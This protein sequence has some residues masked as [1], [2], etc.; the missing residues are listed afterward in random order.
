MDFIEIQTFMTLLS[1]AILVIGTIIGL[2]TFK[3]LNNVHKGIAVYLAAMLFVDLNSRLFHTLFNNN[4]IILLLYSF[5]ELSLLAYFYNKYLFKQKYKVLIA[6]N[7]ISLLYILWEIVTYSFTSVKH[8]HTYTKVVDNFNI[9]ILSLTYFYEKMNEVK[10]S[11]WEYF[12]LNIAIL[13]FFTI[14]LIFFLPYNFL[15]NN[16]AGIQFYFWLGILIITI[17]FYIYLTLLI[18][19]NSKTNI[20]NNRNYTGIST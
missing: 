15:I 20:P 8:F 17:L 4:Q 19:R 7:I 9:I 1:P 11:K 18:W 16:N 2:I 10:Q 14:N 12:R 3:S 13:I 6:M 5:L